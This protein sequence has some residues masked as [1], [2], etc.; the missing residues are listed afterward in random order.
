MKIIILYPI[1]S[2]LFC[3]TFHKAIVMRAY[4]AEIIKTGKIS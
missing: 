4:I 2:S 1:L 3:N